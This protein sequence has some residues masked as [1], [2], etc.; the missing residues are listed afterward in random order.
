M[1]GIIAEE[2][3]EMVQ[4]AADHGFEL[5]DTLRMEGWIGLVLKK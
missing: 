3:A 2:E 5:Y 1:S 4:L